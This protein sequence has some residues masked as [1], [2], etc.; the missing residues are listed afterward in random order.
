MGDCEGERE[1][2]RVA[3]PQPQGLG[4]ALVVCEDE[5]LARGLGEA[6]AE[7]VCDAQRVALCVPQADGVA[8][9][10]SDCVDWMPAPAPCE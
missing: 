5:A 2:L 1:P 6:H 7:G 8:E 10:K 4:E 3:E 9:V